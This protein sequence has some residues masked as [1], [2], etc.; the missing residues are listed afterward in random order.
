MH[1]TRESQMARKPLQGWVIRFAVRSKAG[2]PDA[3]I[4]TG[5]V[6]NRSTA[7]SKELCRKVHHEG[8]RIEGSEWL[9]VVDAVLS[10]RSKHW[11]PKGIVAA[12]FALNRDTQRR[13]RKLRMRYREES[14]AP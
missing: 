4:A 13:L 2:T 1:R 12:I 7:G 5:E 14:L 9:R 11:Y 6:L 10:S 3:A 8:I